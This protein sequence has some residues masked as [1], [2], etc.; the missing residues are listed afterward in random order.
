[1]RNEGSQAFLCCQNSNRFERF[2][3]HGNISGI[4]LVCFVL[5]F[6]NT[7]IYSQLLIIT[8]NRIELKPGISSRNQ[9][10]VI[11]SKTE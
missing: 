2:L 6:L 8:E 5:V 4:I 11:F 9:I 3:F 7:L 1:M 10:T